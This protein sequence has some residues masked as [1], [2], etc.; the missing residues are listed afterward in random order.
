MVSSFRRCILATL[1]GALSLALAACSG[2]HGSPDVSTD[3]GES[4]LGSGPGLV[5]GKRGGIVIYNEA[6][7]G[8]APDSENAE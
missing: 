3:V 2:W 7:S 6:W 8:A 1:L 5:T 4:K